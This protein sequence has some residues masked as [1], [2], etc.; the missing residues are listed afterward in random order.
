M[1]TG[2]TR[3]GFTLVELLVVIAII[4]ILVLML[5]PAINAAREAAR[6]SR[7]INNMKQIGL[8]VAN[9]ESATTRFPLVSS[10]ESG[11]E[12]A[13]P[14]GI[15]AASGDGFSWIV[16]ILPYMEE[17]ILYD[18]IE[19]SSNKLQS[20]AFSDSV[21]GSVMNV[22]A[23]NSGIGSLRCPTYSGTSQS[24]STD[25]TLA[26]KPA[27]G[28]YVALVGTHTGIGGATPVEQN[29]AIV[30]KNTNIVG[31]VGKGFKIRDI[32]DGI[33]KTVLACESREEDY[34]SWYSGACTW[35]VGAD[36]SN[37]ALPDK[38][39]TGQYMLSS[40]SDRVALNV[41]PSTAKPTEYYMPMSSSAWPGTQD[42]KW[43]PS[44]EHSGN[45]I[46]HVFADGHVQALRSSVDKNAYLHIITRSE[47]ES[48]AEGALD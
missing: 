25:F 17:K 45:V 41:G 36:P 1:S 34:G 46:I 47:G 26:Q 22:H 39:T 37:E 31:T 7:C 32:S 21:Y 18:A 6:R 14:G 38:L 48:I 35:V 8:A 10:S 20:D 23:S 40:A 24:N 30:D 19:G 3:R 12:Q 13:K 29:G 9:Q 4:A 27:V 15:G 2:N 5:L 42:R 43:G 33:S 11:L 28:N 16:E 44:S